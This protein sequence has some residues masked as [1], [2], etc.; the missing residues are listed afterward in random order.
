MS[1]YHGVQLA[2]LIPR[3]EN[4]CAVLVLGSNYTRSEKSVVDVAFPIDRLAAKVLGLSGQLST[5]GRVSV[6]RS[7]TCT[8][9]FTC[10][11]NRVSA[12]G[13]SY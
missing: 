10:R 5:W 1:A 8:R 2:V 6:I 3:S 13:R 9:D 7:E 11:T 4:L 12:L